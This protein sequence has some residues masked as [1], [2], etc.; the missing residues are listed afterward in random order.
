[1]TLFQPR[2]TK[3][4]IKADDL[5]YLRFSR[6]DLAR[7][8]Q[9]FRD[10]GLHVSARTE[11]AIYLRGI[12]A[13]HHCVII[14]RGAHDEF[15]ALGIH[16]ASAD[17]LKSL[18]AA[19]NAQ[20]EVNGEPGGGQIVRLLDPVGFRVEVVT[21]GVELPQL[22][23]RESRPMNLPQEKRR[24]NAPQPITIGPTEVYRLGHAVMTRQEFA[25]NA[26]WYVETFGLIASDV[27]V[28]PG[29]REPVLAFMRFD[30]GSKP[31]DH[32]N[33]VIAG[34]PEDGYAHS[35]FETL[36]IDSLGAGAEWLQYQGWI[37]AWG[38]G[39]HVLG[40][41]LFTYHYD[42]AG[43]EVEHYIDGDVFDCDYPTQ[44]HPAG[45]SGLYL[46]GPDLPEKFIDLS[47][48]P[49]RIANILKGLRTRADFTLARLIA[50]KNA[51][52]QKARP[53]IGQN[54][55]RPTAH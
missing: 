36:D 26:N 33:I 28:L 5:A 44:Y 34:G 24:I 3:P 16:A 39:R 2:C 46:W 53:W 40:S 51:Y 54:K 12:L 1:M 41:Q 47:M 35:A 45:T 8:E 37:K 6:R 13:Q 20:V 32:H 9:Y 14:E 38:I 49:K 43:F 29:T 27:E 31:S 11:T 10:F 25:K 48:T 50:M 17:D 22:P 15:I 19:R 55:Q 4:I 7:A 18:A 42:S 52:S 23:Q 21:G 30:R